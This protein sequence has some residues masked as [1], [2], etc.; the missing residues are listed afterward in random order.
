MVHNKIFE[1]ERGTDMSL[2]AFSAR[3]DPQVRQAQQTSA[4][5]LVV[6]LDI[7]RGAAS[8]LFCYRV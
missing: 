3:F 4:H 2:L 7:Q 6:A 8:L 1:R 5:E